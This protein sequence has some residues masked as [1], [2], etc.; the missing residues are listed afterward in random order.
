[1]TDVNCTI[2]EIIMRK[3]ILLAALAAGFMLLGTSLGLAQ[4]GGT[5]PEAEAM[6][7]K[8]IAALK[9][10]E[11]AALK[12]FPT[13]EGGFR[14]RDLYVFCYDTRTG[15][16]TAHAN[17]ALIGVDVRTLKDGDGKP[18][19]QRIFDANK[20]DTIT[21]IDYNYP[22]PGTTKPVPKQSYITIVGH[23]GCGVGYY[24]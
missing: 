7:E 9:A 14:D 13:G 16:F 19:G 18:L 21:T 23:Q 6:L 20:A 8:A 2:R 15:K 5:G 1:M 4:A 10:D 3:P 11:A 12:K 22:R 24:K 17:T